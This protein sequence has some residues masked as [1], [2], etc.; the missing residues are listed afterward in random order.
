MKTK[1]K[2][3]F[4]YPNTMMATLLPLNVSMLSACLKK[5]GC[6]VELFDTTYYKTEDISFE[7]KKV[8]LLQVKPFNL[9]KSG[10]RFKNTDIFED[11]KKHVNGY[12]PDLIGITLVEDTIDLGLSLLEAIQDYHAP[13]I[14]GG[15]GVNFNAEKLIR[16]HCVDMLCIGEGELAIVELFQSMQVGKDYSNLRNLWVKQNG[17][18]IRNSLRG[19]VDI[20]S[21]PY[22][23]FDIFDSS[24]LGRPM[25]GTIYRMI[26]MELDRGCPFNCNYCEAPAIRKLYSKAG[27]SKYHRKKDPE[28]VIAEMKHLCARYDPDYVYFNSEAFL[29]KR[30]DELKEF[31]ESYKLNIGLPFW[32]QSRPETV[33]EEKMALLKEIGCADMQFGIEHGNE[34]FRKKVLNR[35]ITNKAMFKALKAV[36]KCEISYTVNNIIGFPGET[37]R[38]VF[39]TINLNRQISPKTMNCYMF[40]PYHGT[41]LYKY[42]VE[43]GLLDPEAK[44]KQLLGGADIKYEH[45]TREELLGLQRTFSLYARLPESY[46]EKIKIAEKFDEAGNKMFEELRQVFIKM[47]YS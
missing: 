46:Y 23:D 40:T 5:V 18:I 47:F 2:V 31:G 28:R 26:H 12:K 32:C 8:E 34:E 3:L 4:I 7:Q 44:T 13:V 20:N 36:E 27:H 30:Y 14:A 41:S 1:F 37:R 42:C 35:H 43:N 33:S 25:H 29:A 15:V 17:K 9:E 38:L 39:D 11:L 16:H 21:L 24:R 19:P 6:E 10:I 22:I 45:I